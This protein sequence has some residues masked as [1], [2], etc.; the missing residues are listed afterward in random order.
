MGGLFPLLLACA[1]PS[2]PQVEVHPEG[3]RLRSTRGIEAVELLD[4]DGDVLLRRR[5]PAP[6]AELRLDQPWPEPGRWSLRLREGGED[7]RLALDVAEPDPPF[8]LRVDAPIGRGAAELPVEAEAA[9]PAREGEELAVE[10]RALRP[11][12]ALLELGAAR[13]EATLALGERLHL[14]APLRD[15]ER[16]TVRLGED[17][18]TTLLRARP[19]APEA[20]RAAIQLRALR[21]PTDAQGNVD[22]SR[23]ADRLHLPSAAWLR[24]LRALDLGTRARD[25]FAPW[26]WQAVELE[27][28]GEQP[29]NLALRLR[30]LGPDGAPHPAFSPRAREG[31]AETGA[32]Q[33]LL[34]VPA[35]QRATAAL[36]VFLDEAALARQ[37][38]SELLRELTV[39]APG[40]DE[41]LLVER[42]PLYVEQQ[43]AAEAIG[44]SAAVL[45]ALAGAGLLLL[46]GRRWLAEARTSELFTIALVAS[47]GFLVGLATQALT[48]GLSTVLG[49]FSVLVT[50]LLD[51][52]LRTALLAS[53]ITLRPRP[54]TLALHALV[55]WL[56]GGLALGAFTPTDLLFLPG[57]VLWLEGLAW[58]FGLSRDPGWRE[59]GPL[60]RWLRLSLALGLASVLSSATGMV[61]SVTLYR[62]YLA[63]W[64]IALMLALP[65]FLYV[66]IGAALS[67]PV[68]A[69]LREIRR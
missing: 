37:P 47:L 52:T 7:R 54:G 58:L 3:L 46:R 43:A 44:L 13:A 38:T 59:E 20:L 30:L 27:N 49:P 24:A 64:Y 17:E 4:P 5:L 48:L 32:V 65:G 50:G 61:L 26:A 19:P 14:R 9:L 22:L 53:L 8:V 31:M 23:P 29:Q 39:F 25:P 35:G 55:A 68:A 34:R 15:G 33:V 12:P 67:L 10:L 1:A 36:P 56:L 51:D 60:R 28:H 62:L 57:R 11:G 21:F 6:L 41:P 69:R 2:P 66:L 63:G 45:A 18:A 16:L 40:L 42:Q